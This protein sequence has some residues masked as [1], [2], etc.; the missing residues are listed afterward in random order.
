MTSGTPPAYKILSRASEVVQRDHGIKRRRTTTT[1]ARE[2][3]TQGV[4]G[5]EG[6]RS[7]GERKGRREGKRN[8]TS[9]HNVALCRVVSTLGR[10]ALRNEF[11][12]FGGLSCLP[13]CLPARA[14]GPRTKSARAHFHGSKFTARIHG[15][16][17]RQLTDVYSF[18][19]FNDRWML[20]QMA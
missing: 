13:A 16:T 10:S 1:R 4:G 2:L 7:E 18:N 3:P 9:N 19:L 12:R 20:V 14:S 15:A 8:P 5:A 6:G 11:V 17:L